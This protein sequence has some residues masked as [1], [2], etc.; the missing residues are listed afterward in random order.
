ME[1]ISKEI[2]K[3]FDLLKMN[4]KK[5]S[6]K[7]DDKPVL[8]NREI[9][10]HE[11]LFDEDK[12]QLLDWVHSDLR[13]LLKKGLNYS[14]GDI[15]G[16]RKAYIRFILNGC[17]IKD[18]GKYYY[19]REDSIDKDKDD[20]HI[21][22]KGRFCK[23]MPPTDTDIY[24]YIEAQIRFKYLKFLKHEVT[25]RPLVVIESKEVQSSRRQVA[26]CIYLLY[27]S[28]KLDISKMNKTLIEVFIDENFKDENSKIIASATTV[29]NTLFGYDKDKGNEKALFNF[30]NRKWNFCQDN[31]D[32]MIKTFEHDYNKAL[33]MFEKFK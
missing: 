15:V 7:S 22:G 3:R 5:R 27:E 4:F 13:P 21:D 8:L 17:D 24:F 11:L 12:L 26:F 19:V 33:E 2:D 32:Y 23:K 18:E 16:I 14:D 10:V 20:W 1:T 29:K 30:K 25:I 31:F 6:D 28:K 9:Q